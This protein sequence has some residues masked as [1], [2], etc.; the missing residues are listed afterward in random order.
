MIK[1]ARRGASGYAPGNTIEAFEISTRIECDVVEF[2]IH[3]TKDNHIV[4]MHDHTVKST[5]DGLGNIHNL[6]LRQLKD[7][8]EVNGE[9]IPT[10]QGV[11]D[12]L[13]NKRKLMLD[14]KDKNMVD[15][16]LEIVKDN[17]LDSSV[18]VDSDIQEVCMRIKE[19]NPKIHVYLG[20]VT[21]ENF[22]EQIQKAKDINAEMIKIRN[23]LVNKNR[24]AQAHKNGI[25][26]YVWGAEKQ[27][28]IQKMV[29]LEVD[30]IVYHFP[31]KIPTR[32]KNLKK[33]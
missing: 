18:I 23:V 28:E 22:I 33:G 14:I 32:Y 13:K 3:K 15:E 24:V 4:V 8:H 6:T 11:F 2:D 7:F 5:T 9:S 29:D 12:V 17:N 21:E 19:V 1:I 10:L 26:A 25:G 20:G 27:S 16:V 31:D 30:A